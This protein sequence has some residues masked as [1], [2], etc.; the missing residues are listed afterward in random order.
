MRFNYG[1]YCTLSEVWD[2]WQ[3]MHSTSENGHSAWVTL[4]AQPT[5]TDTDSDSPQLYTVFFI[6]LAYGVER[7]YK[8]DPVLHYCMWSIIK[9]D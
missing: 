9:V 3:R 8:H 2:Y 5:H 4:C 6:N 7:W 1:R